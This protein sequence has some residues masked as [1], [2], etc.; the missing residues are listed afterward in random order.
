MQV[1][2][3]G[4]A[5]FDILITCLLLLHAEHD[6]EVAVGV[7]GAA[8]A[9]VAYLAGTLHMGTEAGTHVV[10][11]HID[12][13]QRG[14]GI[15]GELAEVDAGGHLVAVHIA[16]GDGEVGSDDAVYLG[17][18]MAYLLLGGAGGEVVV[19]LAL[20]TFDMV[21]TR[22]AATEKAHHGLIEDVLGGVGRGEFGLVMGVEDGSCFHCVYILFAKIV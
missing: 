8:D 11:A 16:G 15:G 14:A 3:G 6:A 20:L 12:E 4:L 10:V 1:C 2:V 9:E 13:A 17:F 22:A 19:A 18:D 7:A 21:D 5:F